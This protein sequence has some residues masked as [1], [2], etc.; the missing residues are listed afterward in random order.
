MGTLTVR[1]W[2]YVFRGNL[3]SAVIIV[4]LIDC[5]F[6]TRSLVILELY[7]YYT[8]W[9]LFRFWCIISTF[10]SYSFQINPIFCSNLRTNNNSNTEFYVNVLFTLEWTSIFFSFTNYNFKDHCFF[11]KSILSFIVTNSRSGTWSSGGFKEEN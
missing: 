6:D 5:I 4:W 10:F 1:L 8:K 9:N 3:H 2:L 11:N 7:Y